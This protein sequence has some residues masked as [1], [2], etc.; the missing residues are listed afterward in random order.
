MQRI[1]LLS[2][3][4]LIAPVVQAVEVSDQLE[5][6][7]TIEVEYS[8][9]RGDSPAESGSALATGALG[10]TLKPNAH[11]D[12]TTSFLYEEDPNAVATP[13]EV[14]ESYVTWHALP[15]E[16]LD[17][18][19]GKKYLPFGKFSTAMVSDPLTLELGE[20]RSDAVLQARTQRG[21]LT[22][23]G[24][25]F[26]GKSTKTGGASQ[27]NGGYGAGIAYT[28][29]KAAIGADYLSN[30]AESANFDGKRNVNQRIPALAVHGSVKVGER[31]TLLGEHLTA[32][33]RFQVGDVEEDGNG[34]LT[35]PAK[36][37]A[38]HL[39][40]NL[41]LKRDRTLA[42]AWNNTRD[43]A[44][45]GLPKTAYGVAYRQPIYGDL[46]GA[47]E[48][49]RAKDYANARDNTLTLQL[50]YEF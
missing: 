4:L 28:T 46:Q 17:L 5:V 44:E 18:S 35:A 12:I 11:F 50:S 37:A 27:H 42:V 2:G 6:F 26:D 22:T 40:A 23:H 39:E 7:G 25:V 33:K 13:L 1:I 30:L 45:L 10:T 9:R 14:D 41:D 20:T 49:Q 32:L 19:A 31:V 8:D 38:T 34:G 47:L 43:A 3:V 48:W 16:R 36:P 21:N 15:Q 24:W 29:D